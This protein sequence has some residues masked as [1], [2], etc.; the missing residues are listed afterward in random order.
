MTTI[1]TTNTPTASTDAVAVP[2]DAVAWAAAVNELWR[3]A[4]AVELLAA[5][6]LYGTLAGVP[7]YRERFRTSE[8]E[9][10][11]LIS[12]DFAWTLLY[13]FKVGGWRA[14]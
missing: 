11:V 9:S 7:L 10:T 6:Y 8:D 3:P 5:A 4:D 2:A 14:L 13:D 1:V 12:A